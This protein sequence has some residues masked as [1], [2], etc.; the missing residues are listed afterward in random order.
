MLEA[1]PALASEVQFASLA[2]LPTPCEPLSFSGQN[3]EVFVKRDDLSSALYGGNK[4]RTLEVLFGA[5]ARA[6]RQRVVSTGAFGSNHAVATI[7]HGRALGFETGALLCPQPASAVALENLRVSVAFADH[8]TALPHWSCL[9]FGIGGWRAFERKAFVMA[10]G[11]AVPEGALGY[12]SAAFELAEQIRRG[13]VPDPERILL[14]VGSTCTSAGLLVGLRLVRALG[15][16]FERRLPLVY[17]VRVTPWPVTSVYRITHLA[18]RTAAW[19]ARRVGR[20]ELGFERATLASRLRVDG[21]Y[22][23]SGY[24]RV[25]EAGSAAALRLGEF[26]R[27]L[28]STYSAKAAAAL[29]ALECAGPTLFWATKSSAPLPEPGADFDSKVSPALR[30]WMRRAA[31]S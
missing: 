17:A 14:P 11:G 8:F 26:G 21:R 23:G 6:G 29:V 31:A 16:G 10:P 4:V 9:P 19:I 15:L 27:S 13:E 7:L 20:P 24:G 12:V 5:A 18:A 1:L 28:D 25:T 2:T 22:L 3:G 30:R